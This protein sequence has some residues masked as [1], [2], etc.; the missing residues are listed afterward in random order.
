M[1]GAIEVLEPVLTEIPERD[2]GRQLVGDQLVR[3]ARNKHLAAMSGSA[4]PCRA[5]HVQ[6]DVIIQ[7]DFGLAGVD[8]DAH[9]HFDALGPTV[10]RKRPLR[11]HRSRDRIARPHKGDEERVTL[12]VH[13]AAV[14]LVERRAQQPLML[15]KHLGVAAA[16]PRQQPRRT[17]D[18]AE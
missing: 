6:P 9:T 16:K 8:P 1:L 15:G 12:G 7:P 18:V 13:L 5:V 10:G 2:V 14:V 4:D 11:A 17:L 3:G